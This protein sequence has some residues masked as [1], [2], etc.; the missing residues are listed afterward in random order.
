MV[1]HHS[2]CLFS[3]LAV[4][5]AHVPRVEQASAAC[6]QRGAWGCAGGVGFTGQMAQGPCPASPG[7]SIPHL[8]CLTHGAAELR[9]HTL[10]VSSSL[11]LVVFTCA[12]DILITCSLNTWTLFMLGFWVLVF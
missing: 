1:G 7:L 6:K 11:L 3:K 9:G 2:R 4:L 8:D 10:P 12:L 5:Q